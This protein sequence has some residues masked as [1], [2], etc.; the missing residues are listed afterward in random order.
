MSHP[1]A[2]IPADQ[3]ARVFRPLLIA[4]LLITVLFRFIGPAAPT[5]VDFELAGSVAKA[6]DILAAW[7]PLERIH[8]GFSLGFDF[9]YMPIYS[10][11]L[12]LACVWAATVFRSGAWQAIGWALAW[13]AWL[14][15]LFDA[16]ENLALISNLFSGP[17]EPYPQIA[18]VCAALKFGLILLGLLYVISGGVARVF[19]RA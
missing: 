18:A 1:L 3:R 16:I 7:N 8:A 15:A 11:T 14:A 12:A 2:A 9:L 13:G 6:T 4:T 19:K 10:T 17:I 5:I